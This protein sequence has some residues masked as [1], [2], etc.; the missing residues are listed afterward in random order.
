MRRRSFIEKCGATCKN[1]NWSW[2]FVN[3]TQRFVIFG[4]WQEDSHHI[5]GRHLILDEHWATRIPKGSTKARRQPGY[6]QAIEHLSLVAAEGYALFTF[7]IW[8][9]SVAKTGAGRDPSSI[10]RFEP[11]L[12]P[13][14]L[15][16]EGGKWWAQKV[17]VVALHPEPDVQDDLV[18]FGAPELG[19]DGGHSKPTGPGHYF[20][21]DPKVRAEVLRKSG[22]KCERKGCTERLRYKSFLDVHHI[23]GIAKSDRVTNCVALC[24]N[25]HRDAHY[26]KDRDELNKQLHAYARKRSSK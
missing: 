5:A 2:S 11:R 3:K 1:W 21:R 6:P 9:A 26:S 18:D 13:Q 10:A 23:L 17:S 25:C 8:Q 22:G 12:T 4:A 7:P 14:T 24:P 20:P 16:H 15:V 19:R